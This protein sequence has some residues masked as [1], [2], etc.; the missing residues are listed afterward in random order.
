MA[1]GLGETTDPHELIPGEPDLIAEDLRLL[2]ANVER[3]G[4]TGGGLRKIDPGQWTGEGADAFRE[5]FGEE[6]P[7]WFQTIDVLLH[8]GQLLADYGDVLTWAQAEAQRAIEMYVQAQAASRSVAAIP[9]LFDDAAEMLAKEAQAVLDNARERLAAAGG[10]AARAFGF[11]PDGAGGYSMDLGDGKEFGAAERKNDAPG[12]QKG[13]DG[14]TYRGEWGTTQSDGM[15]TDTV[16]DTLRALGFDISEKT[17]AASAG[18][19]VFGGSLDGQFASGPWSGTGKLGG[20]MFGADADATATASALGVTGAAGAEA[21]LA[22]GSAEGEVKLGDHAG[23]S[24]RSEAILG[25]EAGAKGSLGL[26][27]VQGSGEAFAGAKVEGD[28]RAEV[29]GVSAGVHG[30]AWTGA[31][32]EASGQLGMGD[33]GTFHVGASLGIGL[34][35]GGE[36]GFDI[37]IDPE[38]VVD[39]VKDVA[40]DVADIA[41]DVGHGMTDTAEAIGDF[42]GF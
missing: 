19:A 41:S 21:Y 12:R 37:A 35:I 24:G 22:K 32:V 38:E 18:T 14:K 23:V 34:G 6:P 16:G 20:S 7:K 26:S 15:L 36:I 42:L 30:E 5:A 29:A 8:G 25:A 28:A 9:G 2:V 33:D 1:A 27:G 17:W 3:I 31:G 40:D 4:L 39:T 11:E 10:L 13:R